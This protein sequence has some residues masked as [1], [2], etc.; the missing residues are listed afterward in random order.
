[1][2]P[3]L[4]DTIIVII[5]RYP[6]EDLRAGAFGIYH[7]LSLFSIRLDIVKEIDVFFSDGL[8]L[9]QTKFIND[10]KAR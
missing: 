3:K 2:A 8:N 10:S 6:S 5:G 7:R 9:S 1:M 4:F